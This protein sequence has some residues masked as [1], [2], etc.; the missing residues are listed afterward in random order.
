MTVA[1]ARNVSGSG[2]PL[3]GAESGR[4][5]S[6]GVALGYD[7]EA[8]QAWSRGGLCRRVQAEGLHHHSRGQR[9]RNQT[10]YVYLP[11]KGKPVLSD[12]RSPTSRSMIFRATVGM[13]SRS[14]LWPLVN[15]T[16]MNRV[17]L[18][19]PTYAAS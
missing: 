1:Y 6:E 15:V 11:C 10:A 19:S 3:Q 14:S 18:G 17:P 2:S 5:W 7:G 9:P 4:L 16:R 13:I 12:Q 8:L